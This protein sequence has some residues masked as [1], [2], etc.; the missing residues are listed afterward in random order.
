MLNMLQ[1]QQLLW[2]SKLYGI[3]LLYLV[4]FCRRATRMLLQAS[5]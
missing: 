5:C 3:L 1:Q 4:E 2:L